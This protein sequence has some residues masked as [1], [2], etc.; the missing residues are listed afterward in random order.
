MATPKSLEEALAAWSREADA[1]A[2]RA[3][4]A[5]RADV[6]ARF[7][8]ESWPDLAVERYALGTE[9]SAESYCYA[10]EFGSPH[11]GSISGGS[12]RKLLIFKRRGTGEWSCR[13]GGPVRSSASRPIAA[14]RTPSACASPAGSASWPP[15]TSTCW[16]A[17]LTGSW[18]RRRGRASWCSIPSLSG[19]GP[20]AP[21]S[22]ASAGTGVIGRGPCSWPR[23]ATIRPC[24]CSPGA[25]ASPATRPPPPGATAS[26]SCP[27]SPPG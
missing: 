15:A 27:V 18:P 4:E 2:L 3:A 26:T 11:L 17:R 7:P 23:A 6:V 25:S 16:A 12:S 21:R 24:A 13:S 19:C 14:P 10:M 1:D 22:T 20:T 8:R 5:E 9:R